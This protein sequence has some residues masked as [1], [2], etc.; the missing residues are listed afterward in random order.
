[1]FSGE[2]V[3]VKRPI[4]DYDENHDR[5]ELWTDEPLDNVL[6]GRPTTE[7]MDDAMRLYSVE[8]SYVLGIP[9][10]YETS[11]RGCMVYRPRDGRTYRIL[12][13]PLPLPVELCPTP[14]NREASAVIVD[15]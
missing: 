3:T 14:W 5:V 7:Q 1:M 6:F 11:L 10:T 13:D 15:G 2:S 9:N 12:G 8:V 4:Y